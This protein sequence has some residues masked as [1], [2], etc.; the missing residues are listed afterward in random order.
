V[1]VGEG[2]IG[3]VALDKSIKEINDLPEAYFSSISGIAL[4][5]PRNL[6]I[7]PLIYSNKLVAVVE[8][9]SIFPMSDFGKM[10]LKNVSG[11]IAIALNTALIRGRKQKIKF[12]K[13]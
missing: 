9:A 13:K 12:S 2:F 5:K 7:I 6:F 10:F 1:E 4:V 3:Q 11:T 8:L